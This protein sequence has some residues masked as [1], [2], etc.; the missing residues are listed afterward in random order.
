MG[1]LLATTSSSELVEWQHW[2]DRG[3]E[4]A[5]MAELKG[6]AAARLADKKRRRKR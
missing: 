2:Y 5:V 4:A 6:R 1:E 3:G